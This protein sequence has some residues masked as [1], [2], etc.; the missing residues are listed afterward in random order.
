MKNVLIRNLDDGVVECFKKEAKRR[1]TSLQSVLKQT[2]HENQ[3]KGT[4]KEEI[5]RALGELRAKSGPVQEG[6]NSLEV[7]H[8]ERQEREN[9]I[10]GI[11][12]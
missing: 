8:E 6:W 11:Y 2:L 7:I 3:P 1:G 10:M 12:K 4:S 9:R 5:L